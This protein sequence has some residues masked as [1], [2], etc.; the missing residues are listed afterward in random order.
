MVPG[1]D[2]EDSATETSLGVVA[3][4][5]EGEAV[6]Q[7][8]LEAGKLRTDL[9]IL[10]DGDDLVFPVTGPVEGMETREAAFEVR[11]TGPRDYRELL[12]LPDDVH[13][14]LPSSF[15][16]IGDLVLFKL[17]D[18]LEPYKAMVGEALAEFA[19][20][21]SVALDRGVE[22]RWRVRDL[23]VVVGDDD[24]ETVHR[25]HGVTLHV[26]PSRAYFS[27]RLATEHRR[28]A[29]R[30]ADGE[31]V[32]DAFAG[33]GPFSLVIAR[34]AAPARVVAV[35]ANPDAVELLERNVEA[36]DAGDVVEVVAGDAAEV[37]PDL[38]ADRVI[39]NLPHDAAGYLDAARQATGGDG[40]VHLYEIVEEAAVE[41]RIRSL[42]ADGLT[43]EG[44]RAVHHYSPTQELMVFDCREG[45]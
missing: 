29:D 24:L 41:D 28:V 22:G 16:R 23:E 17:P 19:S 32:V 39:M 12:D 27:P 42:E 34:H 14:R 35:E 43:V 11:R 36:N 10:G 1:A 8:L 15:D 38:D 3:P 20:A 33:V 21:R 30:V 2:D 9:Q 6:R 5:R 31:T 26:D 37:L 45:A 40:R 4:R 7:R 13:R 18:D 25:E 44:R